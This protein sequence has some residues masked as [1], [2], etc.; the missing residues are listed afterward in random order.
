[1]KFVEVPGLASV[2]NV[3]NLFRL[4]ATCFSKPR[5]DVIGAY[6]CEDD[7]VASRTE[8]RLRFSSNAGLGPRSL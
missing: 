7:Y 4:G 5:S 2:R 6:K 8:S 3:A 1:M